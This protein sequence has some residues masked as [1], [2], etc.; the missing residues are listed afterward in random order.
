MTCL[1]SV[2]GSLV[3]IFL[4]L[5]IFALKLMILLPQL[6][7]FWDYRHEPPHL[8]KGFFLLNLWNSHQSGLSARR[9]F[10]KH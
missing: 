1:F 6:P 9:L 3:F 2:Q 10:F 4:F 8:S 7:E 5:C